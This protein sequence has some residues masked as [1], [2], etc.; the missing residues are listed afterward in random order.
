M[1]IKTLR[2]KADR[3]FQQYIT[4]KYKRCEICGRPTQVAH[5]YFVKA[6]S[7]SLRYEEKNAIPLCNGCHFKFHS[8]FS[9]EMNGLIIEK[10][11]IK[12]FKS[13]QK[14]RNEVWKT[15]KANYNKVIDQLTD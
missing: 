2:T 11:G 10:R 15:T 6:V 14:Q 5:H 1:E 12:W 13:L 7:S 9:A 4:G 3:L 8:M